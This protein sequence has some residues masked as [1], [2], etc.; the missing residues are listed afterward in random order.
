M[1][2]GKDGRWEEE[3]VHKQHSQI[4]AASA[5]PCLPGP[6]RIIQV[7]TPPSLSCGGHQKSSMN[8][9]LW[10][11]VWAFQ[12][13]KQKYKIPSAKWVWSCL[14]GGGIFIHIRVCQRC[15]EKEH[16]RASHKGKESPNS[17]G[18]EKCALGK[19][20]HHAL[21]TAI[22]VSQCVK[23]SMPQADQFLKSGLQL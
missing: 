8:Y 19:P 16:V 3:G 23:Y 9:T 17:V 11:E 13:Q 12:R 5:M 14:G 10:P 22:T 4:S 15:E 2:K 6:G 20:G 18:M 7:Q 1:S 21:S